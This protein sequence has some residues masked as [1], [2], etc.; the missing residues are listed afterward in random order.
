MKTRIC[1]L[2][3][4]ILPWFNLSKNRTG[5]AEKQVSYMIKSLW[6]DYEFHVLV[7]D[8]KRERVKLGP[9]FFHKIQKYFTKKNFFIN[10]L[11]SR[12]L[13]PFALFHLIRKCDCDIIYQR[14]FHK[15]YIWI[16][17]W[18]KILNKK[19]IYH[20]SDDSQIRASSSVLSP[21]N[22][23][24]NLVYRQSELL[25][26]NN[27]QISEALKINHRV[28]KV[29]QVIKLPVNYEN[30]SPKK[31]P[32]VIWI[33]N[34][35]R[36]KGL[37]I[38]LDIAD[39][40]SNISFV[41][42]GGISD[43]RY[44]SNFSQKISSLNNVKRYGYVTPSKLD[45]LIKEATLLLNTS[46]YEG[47]ANTFL[48]AWSNCLP[49]VS[50]NIDPDDL[51]RKEGIGFVSNNVQELC[52]RITLLIND[53]ELCNKIGSKGREIVEKRYSTKNIAK[54]YKE[55]FEKVLVN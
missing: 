9:I 39:R 28:V 12:L 22:F 41:M 18:S 34:I 38:L 3:P 48:E 40:M 4:G 20:I 26:Q 37:E 19:S 46:H 54:Y 11:E 6:K 13:L 14:A 17:F 53:K 7:Y 47:F 45:N 23:I 27:Y 55:F 43:E 30:P 50:Y 5:G 35:K 51:I 49:V 36:K 15:R 44:F 32:Y 31:V 42:V 24:L 2:S 1:V 29:P 25:A 16:Y 52:N 33:S 21:V 8:L 10:Y